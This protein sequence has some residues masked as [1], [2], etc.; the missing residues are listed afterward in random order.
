MT[1]RSTEPLAQT[2]P[3]SLLGR[4]LSQWSFL[5]VFPRA[6]L[7]QVAHPAVGAGVAEHSVYRTDLWQ[8]GYRTL[9]HLQRLAHADPADGERLGRELRRGHRDIHGVDNHGRPYHALRPEL[10]LWVHA[11][12]LDSIL[13]LWELCGRPLNADERK[14]LY[15][16]WLRV[17]RCLGLRD[18][19]LPADLQ[20]FTAYFS[21]TLTTLERTEPVDHLLGPAPLTPPRP[22]ACLPLGAAGFQAFGR[23]LFP[24]LTRMTVA[25]LPHEALTAIGLPPPHRAYTGMAR[26]LARALNA[27]PRQARAIPRPRPHHTQP[28]EPWQGT[29]H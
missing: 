11:T 21:A 26:G 10:F 28:T 25:L 9:T 16:Q 7:L 18:E 4:S 12:Y 2:G 8:R 27:L 24:H 19:E 3:D 23:G 22:V 5:L 20:A 17:G 14:Q 15:G 1:S 13:T 6:I 29:T